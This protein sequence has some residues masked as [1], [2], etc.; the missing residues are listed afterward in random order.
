MY[1]SDGTYFEPFKQI[2]IYCKQYSLCITM[3]VLLN[4][5]FLCSAL[6]FIMYYLP[7]FCLFFELRLLIIILVSTN[8]S[9]ITNLVNSC[10]YIFF[11]F[12]S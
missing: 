3:F 12:P 11:S 6:Q 8:F 1:S 9:L 5:F 2:M 10:F 4:L 7:F